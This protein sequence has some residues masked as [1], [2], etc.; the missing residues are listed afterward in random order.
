MTNQFYNKL[1][2]KQLIKNLEDEDFNRITLSFYK[3]V[4]ID[5][6]NEKRD[7]LYSDLSNLNIFGRI[8]LAPEGINAQ[9]SVPDYNVKQFYDYFSSQSITNGANIKNAIQ[10]GSSFYKLTI[11]VKKEIVA[12]NIKN[13]EYDIK[14]VG[15]HLNPIEF[16]KAIENANSIV[17]DIRNHYESEVG[18]F[19]NAIIPDVDRSQELLQKIKI[20]LKGKEDDKILLYC[21]GGIRCEKASSYLIK[22]NFS[23]VNQLEGGIINYAH[24]VKKNNLQS[25]F[26]GKNYVFDNRLGERITDDILS[27]CHQCDGESDDH[28][29]CANDL[30]HMLFIQCKN[31][32]KKYSGC[33]CEECYDYLNLDNNQKELKKEEFLKFNENRLKGKVKPKLYEILN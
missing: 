25:K 26:K 17:V 10:E 21:T 29:N 14:K 4:N 12:Y 30:C 28:T 20:L 32:E 13:D 8:Y 15:E 31:C 23:D 11:K 27:S 5:N 7:N 3:Y 18:H 9:I 33:C 6:L 24:E 16:N 2:K 1:G 19:E 22:N